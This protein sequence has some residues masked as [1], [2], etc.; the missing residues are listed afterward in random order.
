MLGG[1]SS[2]KLQFFAAMS[3]VGVE[4]SADP[5]RAAS[6][7]GKRSG[8]LV[9]HREAA[10]L[11]SAKNSF[12]VLMHQ[13]SSPIDPASAVA[14]LAGVLLWNRRLRGAGVR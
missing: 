3:Y 6:R 11:G 7:F 5:S 8:G 13:C 10:R 4:Q 12:A 2:W 9:P 14:V 1:I